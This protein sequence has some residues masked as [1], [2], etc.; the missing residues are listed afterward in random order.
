MARHRPIIAIVESDVDRNRRTAGRTDCLRGGDGS[1]QRAADHR[2]RM[3]GRERLGESCGLGDPD[4]VQR[5][6]AEPSESPLRVERGL[7]V[8]GQ[9]DAIGNRGQ[10]RTVPNL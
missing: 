3:F 8:T 10:C 7:P 6:V 1:L 9:E 5:R 2:G 4:L